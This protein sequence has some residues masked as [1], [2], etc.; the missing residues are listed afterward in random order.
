MKRI[1]KIVVERLT[2]AKVHADH[3]MIKGK[4]S[5]GK[6]D[7]FSNDKNWKSLGGDSN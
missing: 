4:K 3:T 2:G 1:V 5:S 6:E 7:S